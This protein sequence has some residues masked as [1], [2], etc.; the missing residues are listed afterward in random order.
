VASQAEIEE[1]L[2]PVGELLAADGFRLSV[3]P[4]VGD[5]VRLTVTAGPDACAYCLVPETTFAAI[6]LQHLRD[7]GL[8]ARLEIVYPAE[9]PTP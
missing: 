2:R 6:A 4:T 1:A 7:R 5:G 3:G 9:T 8:S